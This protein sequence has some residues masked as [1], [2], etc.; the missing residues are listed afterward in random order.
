[1]YTCLCVCGRAWERACAVS[2]RRHLPS[3]R[4]IAPHWRRSRASGRARQVSGLPAAVPATARLCPLNRPPSRLQLISHVTFYLLSPERVARGQSSRAAAL[5]PARGG[6]CGSATLGGAA[7]GPGAL[8]RGP[9]A[10][11]PLRL[12]GLRPARRAAV[13]AESVP[14]RS[15]APLGPARRRAPEAGRG[16][17]CAASGKGAP[18]ANLDSGKRALG[19]AGREMVARLG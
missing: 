11:E 10:G 6:V 3:T 19:G 7:G 2:T 14:G 18:F 16:A 8:A 17:L 5:T 15:P 12:P 4:P 13:A 9:S 1:M